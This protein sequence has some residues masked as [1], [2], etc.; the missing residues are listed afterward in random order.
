MNTISQIQQNLYRIR[1]GMKLNNFG[2]WTILMYMFP[3][4]FKTFVYLNILIIIFVSFF[5]MFSKKM[6]QKNFQKNFQKIHS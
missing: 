2:Y 4:I 3:L 6:N 5:L 1:M